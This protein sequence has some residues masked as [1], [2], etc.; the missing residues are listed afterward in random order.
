MAINLVSSLDIDYPESVRINQSFKVSISNTEDHT[1]DI[2]I[3]IHNSSDDKVS[4]NEIISSILEN[5]EWKDS[6]LYILE[7]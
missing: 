5:E 2:K 3:F 6:Y 7:A 4:R 1:Y